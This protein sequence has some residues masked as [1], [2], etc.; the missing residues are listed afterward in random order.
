MIQDINV[1]LENLLT[2]A[3]EFA[4]SLLIALATILVGYLLGRIIEK[5]IKR[6][7]LYLNSRLNQGLQGTT[8]NVDL[9]SLAT[10]VSGLFFWVIIIVSLLISIRVLG[11]TLSGVWLDKVIGF[12][13]NLIVAIVIVLA[14]I[15]S[16]HLLGR[17]IRKAAIRTGSTNGR[18]LSMVVRYLILFVALVVAV[19][20]IGIDI[21][22][23]KDL[24]VV[25]LAA[26]LFGASFSFGLGAK[27]SISNILGSYYFRKTH[28]LGT[29]IRF[30]DIEGT[31]VKIT[32][33]SVSLE[34]NEGV[35]VIPAK[36]FSENHVVIVR[37][38]ENT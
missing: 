37:K 6:L 2:Q 19:D 20:Q 1:Y 36:S 14:G 7:I 28:Q 10:F 11:L 17:L 33:Y 4:P 23:L 31:I 5:L 25:V 27:T 35:V 18:Y 8:I 12:L 32:D 34:T 22:F 15:T 13:P 3:I 26:L 24:L 9:S 38:D 30:G 21:V 29:R 16:G